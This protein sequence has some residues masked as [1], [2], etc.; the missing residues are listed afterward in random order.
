[1]IIRDYQNSDYP[2]IVKLWQETGIADEKRGD[3]REVIEQCLSIGGKLL[4]MEDDTAGIIMGTSWMTFDGRR[5]HLHHFCIKPAYQGKGHGS[6]LTGAS[7]KYI[8]STGAQVKLEVHA[9][10]II[11]R[12]LYEKYG[13]VL[14]DDYLIYMIRDVKK[15]P[16]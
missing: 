4:V 1:M 16:F 5:I 11:A 13:F 10:N 3:T 7:L 2:E 15:I 12:N 6:T 14:F 9:G 8:K